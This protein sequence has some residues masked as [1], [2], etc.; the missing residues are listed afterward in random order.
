MKTL[1][2]ISPRYVEFFA[3]MPDGGVGQFVAIRGAGQKNHDLVPGL[4]YQYQIHKKQIEKNA[5]QCQKVI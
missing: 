4:L 5:K 2:R 1:W 3:L